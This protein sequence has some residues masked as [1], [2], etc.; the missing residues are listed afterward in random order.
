MSTPQTTSGQCHCGAVAF[1]GKGAIESVDAC[2]C[3]T[4]RALNG[5]PYLG[6]HFSDGVS[7]AAS[8]HLTWYDSSDWARRAFCGQCG[9]S[10]FYNMKG[11][12]FYAVSSGC[13]EVPA[14]MTL[15]QEGF[16]D[17]KPDFYNFAGDH[18][19]LTGAEA[20][21]SFQ[22]ENDLKEANHD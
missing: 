12:D 4:C 11:T 2:H 16:V 1:V 7:I 17:E 20:I 9:A 19:R 14:G 8:E 18:P 13:I 22:R 15:G 3:Q 5:G 10:L 6:V 21:A